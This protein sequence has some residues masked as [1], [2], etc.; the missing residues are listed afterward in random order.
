VRQREG[1][2]AWKREEKWTDRDD[3]DYKL[4]RVSDVGPGICGS[5]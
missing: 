3:V 5:E 2:A 1:K 4:L